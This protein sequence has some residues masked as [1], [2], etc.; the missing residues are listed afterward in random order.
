MIDRK[1]PELPTP[2][3]ATPSEMD[4]VFEF[5]RDI[6]EAAAMTAAEIAELEQVEF[7]FFSG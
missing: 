1:H 5:F 6:D 7:L 3:R 4:E 2:L